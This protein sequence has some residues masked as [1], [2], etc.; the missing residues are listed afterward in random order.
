MMIKALKVA[1]VLC[2]V[3]AAT[4]YGCMNICKKFTETK[5]PGCTL[6]GKGCKCIF[7]AN[8][9]TGKLG[10]SK[11]DVSLTDPTTGVTGSSGHERSE[12][13]AGQIAVTNLFLS[14]LGCN[15]HGNSS[16][17]AGGNSTCRISYNAC[18]YWQSV[19]LLQANVASL[20]L[21][22]QVVAP[23]Q[24]PKWMVIAQNTSKAALTAA[25]YQ[26]AMDVL[27]FDPSCMPATKIVQQQMERIA[28]MM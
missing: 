16:V 11:Y 10:H 4:A 8:S 26:L 20:K 14:D 27:A 3:V 2:V 12:T 15:C 25:G 17:P 22:V 1:A 13:L 6:R 7:E 5:I 28:K 21:F 18:F 9:K 19:A 24:S 23:R